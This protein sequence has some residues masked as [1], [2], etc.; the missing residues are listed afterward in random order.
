LD[1][2][3]TSPGGKNYRFTLTANTSALLICVGGGGA[4]NHGNHGGQGGHGGKI[5]VQELTMS[6]GNYDLSFNVGAGEDINSSA[7]VTRRGGDSSIIGNSLNSNTAVADQLTDWGYNDNLG[8]ERSNDA[9]NGGFQLKYGVNTYY[10]GGGGGGG[11]K[12]KAIGADSAGDGYFGGQ[13]GYTDN[14]TSTRAEYGGG[15]GG[16]FQHG[17]NSSSSRD[18]GSGGHG[19]CAILFKP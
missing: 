17:Y 16:G 6:A 1:I 3:D 11:R 12:K 9:Q 2:F 15:G 8:G 13:N 10:I 4:G 7:P 5:I 14:T 18:G 19:L